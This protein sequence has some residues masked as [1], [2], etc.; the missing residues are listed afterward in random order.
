M[1]SI[2]ERQT[3]LETRKHTL[4]HR[5]PW[6]KEFKLLN[7]LFRQTTS[8]FGASLTFVILL[9]VTLSLPTPSRA[10]EISTSESHIR[11]F[12]EVWNA[13]RERYYDPSLRGV[14]WDAIGRRLRPEAAGARSTAELYEVLRRMTDA[15][16]DSHTR[17]RSPADQ[18]D[19]RRP[20][21]VNAGF[22]AR[23]IEGEIIVTETVRGS[24]A[25]RAGMQM[26][27][28]IISINGSSVSDLIERAQD[29]NFARRDSSARRI[30]N[31]FD[32]EANSILSIE[33]SDRRGRT[34]TVQI[35]RTVYEREIALRVRCINDSACVM[36]FD[37]FT[38]R[39][40]A[41][42]A[43]AMRRSDVSRARA[44]IIDLRANGGGD[45]E[46]ML[47][48]L[49]W[50]LTEGKLVGNFADRRGIPIIELRTR[51]AMLLASD[52]I[53]HFSAPILILTSARTASAAEI[54]VRALRDENRARTVGEATCGCVLGLR[55]PH[56]LSDGG[57]LEISE[58]DYRT[59]HG[60]RLEGVPTM[61]D[62]TIALVRSDVYARRD[63][64]L[65]RAIEIISR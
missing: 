13:V 40:A 50:F 51:A 1:P 28:K 8:L 23:R 34:Q 61:A 45:A 15:L 18:F 49:S 42:F 38:E 20:R 32:G 29:E 11:V 21:F 46:A 39:I 5:L 58:M 10:S 64:V 3:T 22:I 62:E 16:G 56:T 26:G 19:W 36:R 17:V 25:E 47:D 12:D 30:S 7:S 43:R 41:E 48:M 53:T 63:A 27:D 37:A 14:D 6:R 2:I 4:F 44:L 31:L 9:Q 57:T 24:E 54:F 52:R 65:M 59:A 60:A 33:F 55:R 35:R